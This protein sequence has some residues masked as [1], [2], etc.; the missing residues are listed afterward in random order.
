MEISTDM[1]LTNFK[2]LF[3]FS[4]FLLFYFYTFSS[5]SLFEFYFLPYSAEETVYMQTLNIFSEGKESCGKNPAG[6][7][8]ENKKSISFGYTYLNLTENLSNIKLFLPQ[9][10]GN[11]C[12]SL[13]Y[14][15]FGKTEFVSENLNITEKTMYSFVFNTS[16]GKEMFLPS[17][18][19]GAD[20]HFG[21]I[22]L[23]QT[24]QIYGL[25]FG[26]RY[27]INF[28]STELHIATIFGSSFNKNES[29]TV[30]SAGVKYYLPEYKSFLCLTYNKNVYEFLTTTVETEL[31]KNLVLI[32]GYETTNGLTNYSFGTKIK[33]QKFDF[34]FSILYNINLYF[35]PSISLSFNL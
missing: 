8:M 11:L 1:K 9:K 18:F 31:V 24:Q 16:L 5:A 32:F 28:V 30:Y 10:F 25:L 35:T 29:L 23:D 27:I 34:F 21:N 17:L 13:K 14:G 4:V 20:F 7:G 12:F 33:T 15:N 26:A 19:L 22:K 3:C 2:L 6:C